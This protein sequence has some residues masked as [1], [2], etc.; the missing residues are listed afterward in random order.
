MARRT[1]WIAVPL[2]VAMALVACQQQEGG[3]KPPP[4]IPRA[5]LP[6]GTVEIKAIP[7]L[8]F[9]V[10]ELRVPANT[11]VTIIFIN[12]DTAVPHD[13]TIWTKK[14]GDKIANTDI[15]TGPAR[16]TLAVNL[17]PGKYYFNC[18]VHPTEMTGTVMAE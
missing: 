15:I 5:T 1:L 17:K 4:T 16:A 13:F 3:A 18:T 6:P 9:N 2:I 10:K 8:K 7:T 11:N 12:E 14:D